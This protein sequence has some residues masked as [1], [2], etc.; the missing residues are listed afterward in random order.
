MPRPVIARHR[1][2]SGL[3]GLR[4][5]DVAVVILY[6]LNVPGFVGGLLGVGGF[7]RSPVI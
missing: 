3:D 2:V 6:H 4:T 5:I 1:Y 7:S